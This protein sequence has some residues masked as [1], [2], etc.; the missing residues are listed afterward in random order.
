MHVS[1]CFARTSADTVGGTVSCLLFTGVESSGATSSSNPPI[2]FFVSAVISLVIL[3]VVFVRHGDAVKEFT[4]TDGLASMPRTDPHPCGLPVPTVFELVRSF[5]RR[6]GAGV[7]SN[8]VHQEREALC[9][10]SMSRKCE[11]CRNN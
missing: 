10:N 2:S 8:S 3:G 7:D 4:T 5:E 11:L 1:S 9:S 6:E